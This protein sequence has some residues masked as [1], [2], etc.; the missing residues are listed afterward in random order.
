MPP[1]LT[2]DEA[3]LRRLTRRDWTSAQARVLRRLGIPFK[4]S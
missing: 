2:L 3:E 4:L 1:M